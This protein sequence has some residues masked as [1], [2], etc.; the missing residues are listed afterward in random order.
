MQGRMKRYQ[1]TSQEVEKLLADE[2]VGRI[3][4]INADGSPYITPVHF[5]YYS[6]KI[7][8]HG[9]I[10][11]QK[12]INIQSNPN[13]CFEIDRMEKLIMSDNPCDVNTAYQS[14]IILGYASLIQ[15]EKHKEVILHQIIKKYTPGLTGKE[16]PS[17]M[18]NATSVVEIEIKA[19]TG[20]YYK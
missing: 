17:R 15:N 18:L 9:L 3:A 10:K 1:L 14:V 2:T 8:I 5:V 20:K 12:I 13:V 7:Y 19:C 16:L 4:T 6:E 11:G